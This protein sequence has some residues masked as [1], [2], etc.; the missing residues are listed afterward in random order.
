[1]IQ[2]KIQSAWAIFTVI[3]K[4]DQKYIRFWP[5]ISWG[6]NYFPRIRKTEAVD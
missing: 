1:M 3:K 5:R 6:T 4:L 2:F